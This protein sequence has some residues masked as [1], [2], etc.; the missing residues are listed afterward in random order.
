MNDLSFTYRVLPNQQGAYYFHSLPALE[1][2]GLARLARLPYSIRVLLEMALRTIDGKAVTVE[3][4]L[5]LANWSPSSAGDR[6]LSFYP[7]RVL[8]QDLTGV[9]VLV[10]LAALRE[11]FVQQGGAAQA[12]NPL[13]PVDLVIDHSIQVDYAGTAEA[14]AQN[15]AI[16]Y[17]RNQER[18]RFLRWAQGAFQNLRI[19]PPGS[20]IVHQVN[21]EYLASLVLERREGN[22]VTLFPDSVFGT[23]SHTTM[24]NGLGVLG[25]GVG[26]IEAIAAMLK[27]PVELP[28]PEVTGVRLT[29]KLAPGVTPT[30]L[31]LTLT[32][33]LRQHGVVERFVE[34]TGPGLETLTAADRV[35]IANMAPEYGATASYFPVDRQT[36]DYLALTGRDEDHIALVEAYY[37]AQGMFHEVH[38]PEPEFSD[39]LELELGAV[40]PSLAGP[41]RPQDRVALGSVKANFR[42]ALSAPREQRGYALTAEQAEARTAV[43]LNGEEHPLGNGVLVLA[44]ITS[45]TNTS[46]PQVLI[47][48]GLLARKAVALG[49]HPPPWVKTSFAPGSR[50]VTRYLAQAG[51]LAPL[52]ELGF[53]PVGFGCT[54][55]IGNSGPL[56]AAVAEAINKGKLVAAAVLSGNRN[57]EGRVHPLV[58]ANYLASPPLVVAY[59]LAGRIDIDLTQEPL[60]ISAAGDPVYLSDLFP[61]E[62]TLRDLIEH[63]LHREMFRQNYKQIFAGNGEWQRIPTS[64]TPTYRWDAKSTYLHLPPYFNTANRGGVQPIIGARALVV[65]GDSITTDH[66]SP[67]GAIAPVS[68]A[69]RYL[70]AHSVDA[71]DFNTYG[72]RR[73]HDEVMVR[74]TFANIRLRNLLVPGQE[75]GV[76][77]HLPDGETLPIHDAA[78]R[79]RSQGVPLIVIAG[80]EYGTGSSRDWA[81]KGPRL[82]GVQAV[83]AI[84]YERIHRANLVGMGILPLQFLPG[85]NLT[86][87]GL[88]GEEEF[89]LCGMVER[90]TPGALLDI[91]ARAADGRT[92]AFKAELRIHSE[93]EIAYLQQGGLLPAIL[94][95]LR[96]PT[97]GH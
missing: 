1:T 79:Y 5:A 93:R 8:L 55:C 7:G 41:K 64:E 82:L 34:F 80:R 32:Q 30:D 47:T 94:N 68:P 20:G 14:Q 3:D 65:L 83:L 73:G 54:T 71:S 76:T 97:G 75:G 4:A 9:P 13:L 10:D 77:R 88:T 45:C 21:I 90:L 87:L 28:V 62:D 42:A 40:E 67:A 89:T 63:S 50:V 23:D 11:A 27:Q 96:S 81:A 15:L 95:D 52:A 38:L 29:G 69:A 24:V 53:Q 12:I 44:A 56:D 25:W 22:R 57:F 43:V 59:A 85:E 84:S 19:V 66:I 39:L 36:L 26:G 37:R 16:E 6:A 48:A 74:G 49:L 17:Q 33:L 91:Q 92:C 70:R 18:Y 72:S 86:S 60:G 31:T 61:D 35:M 51:L 46:N 78:E 2:A 58:Q